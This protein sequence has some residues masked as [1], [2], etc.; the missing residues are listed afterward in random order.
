[1][2]QCRA[3][4]TAVLAGLLTTSCVVPRDPRPWHGT[5]EK[6]RAALPPLTT[7]KSIVEKFGE[8]ERWDTFTPDN[9]D[10]SAWITSREDWQGLF[11]TEPPR[12]IATLPSGTTLMA[13]GFSTIDALNP[14]TGVAYACVDDSDRVIG[15]MYSSFLDAYP[16]D[17]S[18]LG[19]PRR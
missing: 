14:T 16:K 15:W 1:M 19:I 4:L 10:K 13:Y 5:F 9:P 8:P 3:L 7:G 11:V 18:L 17:V 6:F 12:L 2:N